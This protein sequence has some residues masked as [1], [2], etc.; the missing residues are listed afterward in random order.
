MRRAAVP[1]QSHSQFLR[2]GFSLV[3]LLV[4]IILVEVA[5]LAVVQTTAVVVRRRNE[6]HARAGAVSAATARVEQVLASPCGAVAGAS[7]APAVIEAWSSRLLA[8]SREVSDSVAF[9]LPSFHTFVLRTRLP[10]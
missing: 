3:E 4:A 2:A 7:T 9:G 8:G 6:A 5:L 1:R 10:C